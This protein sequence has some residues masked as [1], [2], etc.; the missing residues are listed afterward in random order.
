MEAFKSAP[1]TLRVCGG[2]GGL[3]AGVGSLLAEL[4]GGDATD[5]GAVVEV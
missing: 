5:A 3:R 2:M 4:A 1:L